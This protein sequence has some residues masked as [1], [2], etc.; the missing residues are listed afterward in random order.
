SHMSKKPRAG[1]RLDIL[2]AYYVAARRFNLRDALSRAERIRARLGVAKA[3]MCTCA[4]SPRSAALY[5][6]LIASMHGNGSAGNG[7]R[8]RIRSRYL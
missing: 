8:P 5:A 3:F 4:M 6:E 7:K 2:T 1:L